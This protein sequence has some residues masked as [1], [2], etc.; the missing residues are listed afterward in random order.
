MLSATVTVR[1]LKNKDTGIDLSI[2]RCKETPGLLGSTYDYHV[3]VVSR[4]SFFKS[5]KH[6]DGDVVQFMVPRKYKEFEDLHTKLN[7]VHPA[8]VLP[9]IPRKTLVVSRAVAMERQGSLEKFL[10]FLAMTPKLCTS[11]PLLQFLG[12]SSMKAGSYRKQSDKGEEETHPEHTEEIDDDVEGKTQEVPDDL[13]EEEGDEEIDTDLFTADDRLREDS[14]ELL[15]EQPEERRTRLFDNPDLGGAVDFGEDVDLFVPGSIEDGPSLRP[16]SSLVTTENNS[17]LFKIED[18][19]DKLLDL[20]KDTKKSEPIEKPVLEN[21]PKP[22]PRKKPTTAK[23]PDSPQNSEQNVGDVTSELSSPV[24][25]KP[26]PR[27][28]PAVKSK[29]A[30][31]KKPTLGSKPQGSIENVNEAKPES[32]PEGKEP[33]GSIDSATKTESGTPPETKTVELPDKLSTDDISKYI[34]ENIAADDEFDDLFS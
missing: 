28:K 14:G 27:S 33:Q 19:L 12:V 26:A 31:D 11:V 2:P 10:K 20:K 22:A 9:P 1:E 5:P 25:P 4:L 16:E 29:P 3:V 21:R 7:E 17:D 15:E 30:L 18:D 24:Q 23:K 13:F 8:T 34:Q 32:T 6:K